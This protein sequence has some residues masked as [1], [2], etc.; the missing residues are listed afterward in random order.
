[1]VGENMAKKKQIRKDLSE[2]IKEKMIKT[3]S[4]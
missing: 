2:V 4:N 3:D 1:M